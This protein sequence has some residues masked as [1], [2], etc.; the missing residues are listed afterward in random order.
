MWNK[1]LTILVAFIL[2]FS[3][4]TSVVP[5]GTTAITDYIID[6]DTVYIDDA[7]AY[8]AATPHTVD[9]SQYVYLDIISKRFT[10]DIDI[11]F[12]FNTQFLNPRSLELE[13]T[14]GWINLAS[15][16]DFNKIMYN[17]QGMDTWYYAKNVPV[18][19]NIIYHLRMFLEVTPYANSSIIYKYF[20]ALKPSS[21]TI[22]EA[23]DNNHL[24]VLD[25]WAT[26]GW[27]Q[28]VQIT[29][30]SDDVGTTLTNY[31]VLLTIGASSGISNDD[32]T[33]IFDEVED[34]ELKIAFTSSDEVT[35]LYAE[36]ESWNNVTELAYVWVLVPSIASG[37]DTD[38]YMYF[39]AD[40]SDNTAYIGNDPNDAATNT[41][42]DTE[43]NYAA[44]YHKVDIT[45]SSIQDSTSNN[46]D[47]TKTGA[48][49]PLQ[50]TNIIGQSQ[51]YDDVNDRINCGHDSSIHFTDIITVELWINATDVGVANPIA[52]HRE[53]GVDDR[54]HITT[55][56]AAK[57]VWAIWDGNGER[58]MTS[59]GAVTQYANDYVVCTYDG[60]DLRVFINGAASGSAAYNG[61]I[62]VGTNADLFLGNEGY[63]AYYHGIIDEV[64]IHN[65]NRSGDWISTTYENHRDDFCEWGAEVLR[66]RTTNYYT[67]TV[68]NSIT[69]QVSS[70]DSVYH[71]DDDTST[72]GTTLAGT[73]IST[74][75]VTTVD[76]T[77]IYSVDITVSVDEGAT[78]SE[79]LF[80]GLGDPSM[81]ASIGGIVFLIM[82][83]IPVIL[84]LIIRSR[85]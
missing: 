24:F 28:R 85:R 73:T 58:T 66:P 49:E 21:E 46:N 67:T 44:V 63:A 57:I 8:I 43:T 83:F 20:I 22:Q 4:S 7:N 15:K 30:E 74:T 50:V 51:Q 75:F 69:T 81:G 38:I 39:D 36:V 61:D 34:E 13:T 17:F 70:T 80:I 40:V 11:C 45:T 5:V 2:L 16:L 71:T 72:G 84:A 37:S 14:Q 18:T 23:K 60:D 52:G 48:N 68:V 35:Q 25:P 64:R 29:I 78:V 62:D 19:E 27:D 42:W 47:G 56:A 1:K 3:I 9:V 6:G 76:L 32:V 79:D 55:Q 10:G 59:D 65:A 12:G 41:V 33:F 31:P 26:G 53:S 54:W 77:T 82:I